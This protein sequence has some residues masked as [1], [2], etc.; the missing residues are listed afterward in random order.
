MADLDYDLDACLRYNPQDDI[1][2]DAIEH[3]LAVWEGENDGDDWRWIVAL[4]DGRF[5]FIQ[6]GCDYTGWDCSSSAMSDITNTAEAAAA[7]AKSDHFPNYRENAEEVFDDLMS[8]IATR[9]KETWREQKDRELG[10]KS[11]VR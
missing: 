1:T 10:V 4:T 7:C 5:A 11:G 8:Q 9:K 2:P 3:V 6:G